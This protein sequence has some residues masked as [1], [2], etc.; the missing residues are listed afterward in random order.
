[1][2]SPGFGNRSV[3]VVR[4]MFA[5]PTT[6]MR[7]R[8]GMIFLRELR[9]PSLFGASNRVNGTVLLMNSSPAKRSG[10][11]FRHGLRLR[12]S[13]LTCGVHIKKSTVTH[14]VLVTTTLRRTDV[15]AFEFEHCA[16]DD[17]HERR[18]LG[19]VGQYL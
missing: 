12:P 10:R 4:S 1:M 6:A 18:L 13:C 17:D 7:G 5:L 3:N 2:V 14:F 15:H 11:N 8:R 9:T 19:F 16:A